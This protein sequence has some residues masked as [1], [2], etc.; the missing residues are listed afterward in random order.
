MY[1][2]KISYH[3]DTLYHTK[4]YND[5]VEFIDQIAHSQNKLKIKKILDFGCGT[6][7]HSLLLAEYGYKLTGIDISSEMIDQALKKKNPT[8]VNFLNKD[9]E[10]CFEKDF[11]MV[12]SMFYVINHI[13]SISDIIKI[14]KNIYSKL[15]KDGLF[16][17]DAWNGAAVFLD[18][19]K[20]YTK[21][22]DLEDSR[23]YTIISKAES[24]FFNQK[25]ILKNKITISNQQN[26][27]TLNLEIEH[28]IWM[29][30]TLIELAEFCGFTKIK[31]T[32]SYTFEKN[33]TEKDWKICFIFK[34]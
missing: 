25:T 8:K 5:E 21:T 16:I 31:V 3:Y 6:G 17:F 2:K 26:T 19:P 32:P 12:I 27:E 24:N 33:A 13:Q 11:D 15:K 9:I 10:N 29:P 23:N 22:V 1:D 20:N 4:K 14:F 28:T 34:K 7:T 30:K 18:P